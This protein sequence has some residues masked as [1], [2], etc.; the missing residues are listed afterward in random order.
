VLTWS[1]ADPSLVRSITFG[2]VGTTLIATVRPQTDAV[3]TTSVTIFADDG[4]SKVGQS[5]SLEVYNEGPQLDPIPDQTT[6]VNV[7]VT[8]TLGVRDVDTPLADLVFTGSSSNPSLVSGVAVST[9]SGAAVAT[10]SLVAN[11]EGSAVVTI[12][13][14][15]GT[16]ESSQSFTLTVVDEPPVLGAIAD[17]TTTANTPVVIT[18]DVSDPDT[19]LSALVFSSSTSN[20]NL[21]AGVTVDVTT[22]SA[23]ATVNLVEDATGVA[24]VTIRVSDGRTQVSQT[25]ALQVVADETEPQLAVPTLSVVDGVLT[26]NLT[27]EHGGELEYAD[28]AIGPWMRTGNTSGSFSEPAA[29]GSR[30]YRV[31][32]R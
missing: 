4:T 26:I 21:V 15:D 12:K 6:K 8:L 16:T 7:P 24:T 22:G 2:S 25:F 31:V 18:L 9:E 27:W 3:G 32:R 28:S 1:S 19:A 17:Q 20:T 14:S 13:V 5:F 29:Q 10:V 30:V 23:V 11:A